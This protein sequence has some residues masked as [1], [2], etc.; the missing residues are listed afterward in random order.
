V[1]PISNEL[2]TASA[3]LGIQQTV[4]RKFLMRN[5]TAQCITLA[6]LERSWN[7][8]RLAAP[9]VWFSNI[10]RVVFSNND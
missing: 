4:R 7:A 6:P 8:Y 2:W 10:W 5:R 3:P 9:D 1:T